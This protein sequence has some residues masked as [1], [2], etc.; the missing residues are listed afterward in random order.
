MR[1]KTMAADKQRVGGVGYLPMSHGL[2]SVT[3][4]SAVAQ[5]GKTSPL[6]PAASRSVALLPQNLCPTFH[7]KQKMVTADS[8]TVRRVFSILLRV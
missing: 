3:P 6:L 2:L 5:S 8:Q 7:V 4:T 1:V